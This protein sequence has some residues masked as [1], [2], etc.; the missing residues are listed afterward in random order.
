MAIE[1]FQGGSIPRE[2]TSGAMEFLWA[3]WRALN[4]TGGLSLQRLTEE[5]SYQ[6][7]ANSTYMITV[8]DDF[9]FMYIGEAIQAEAGT[10]RTGQLISRSDN[11][12]ARDLLAVYRQSAKTLMPSF[13][14]FSGAR[15]GRRIWQGLVLP[16][17]LAPGTVLLV[18]YSELISHQ[19]EVCEHLF[20]TSRDAM[21][22]A[23]PIANEAG[24]VLD[25]WV[26]MMNDA[27]RE[28]L[29]FQDS[30]GNLRLKHLPL[31][32][33][34]EFRFKLH[35]P[36]APGS[37]TTVTNGDGYAAEII[38]FAHVFAMRLTGEGKGKAPASAVQ[39][40]AP[41]LAPV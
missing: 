39:E 8:G 22:I 14:R 7:A 26:V 5:S 21:L 2:L 16:I 1:V 12:I 10:N 37:V 35:P 34:L 23:S 28:F 17:K 36:V 15:N 25:G 4:A 3:K 41:A 40:D 13:V 32:K 30:I 31:V 24:D 9:V 19:S 20:Q 6:L 27:A 18:C 33:D 29:G 11:P 38:R